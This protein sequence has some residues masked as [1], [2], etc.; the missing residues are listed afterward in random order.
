[1]Q[2]FAKIEEHRW[3]YWTRTVSGYSFYNNFF[4]SVESDILKS[5]VSKI[6]RSNHTDSQ[7][8]VRAPSGAWIR[9]TNSLWQTLTDNKTQNDEGLF[10]IDA[11]FDTVSQKFI[12]WVFRPWYL[13]YLSYLSYGLKVSRRGI[14]FT[15]FRAKFKPRF[16]FNH[17]K[18]LTLGD[19]Y[20]IVST[21]AV[22][23]GH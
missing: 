9:D 23:H 18:P 14:S 10:Y 22:G 16:S 19:L 11:K 13:T 7:R 5:M 12:S 1:M 15:V 2:F 21:S 20:A 3:Y 6:I 4:H 17:E 8:S